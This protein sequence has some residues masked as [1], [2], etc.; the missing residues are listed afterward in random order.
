[1]FC[2]CYLAARGTAAADSGLFRS[3]I[4]SC[5]TSS[6]TVLWHCGSILGQR[7][8]TESTWVRIGAGLLVVVLTWGTLG[9]VIDLLAGGVL[10]Y[11][12]VP[13]WLA[14]YW[15]AL[16]AL[17]P[18]AAVLVTLRRRTGLVLAAVVLVTDAAANGYAIHVPELGGTFDA[19]GRLRQPQ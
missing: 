13:A 6:R 11:D 18:A 12:A 7:W 1:M 8:T 15:V 19:W 17:E 4:S 3:R 2:R 16:T 9:H 5:D 14:G 10:V